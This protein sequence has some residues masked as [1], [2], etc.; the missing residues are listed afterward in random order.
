MRLTEIQNKLKLI[1]GL[2][3][4]VSG[5]TRA[6]INSTAF[7]GSLTIANL[8]QRLITFL[9]GL[10]DSLLLEGDLTGLFKVLLA[11]LFL[12]GSELCHISVV[13][14]LD[15]F[16]GTFQNGVFLDGF[17]GFFLLHAAQTGLGVV[18]TATE[19]DSAL[20]LGGGVLSLLSALAPAA[21]A[22][23]TVTA[24]TSD[25]VGGGDRQ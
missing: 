23:T 11:N 22:T 3:L 20:D 24:T 18:N 5:G 2:L 8:F 25:E 12:S 13:A 10:I 15:I 7:L 19:I 14:F 9:D 17:D 16:V 1:T 4:D 21:S 6:L